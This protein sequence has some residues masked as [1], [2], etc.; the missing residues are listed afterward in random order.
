MNE[1]GYGVDLAGQPQVHHI[2]RLSQGTGRRKG[3]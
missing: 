2:Y 1:R 3:L